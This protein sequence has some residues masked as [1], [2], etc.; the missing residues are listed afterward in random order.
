LLFAEARDGELD[1]TKKN[2]GCN[3]D[4]VVNGIKEEP[5]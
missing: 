2:E 4:T 1:S 3:S 5:C